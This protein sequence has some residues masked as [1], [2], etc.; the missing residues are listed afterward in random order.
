MTEQILPDAQAIAQDLETVFQTIHRTPELGN[1]EHRTAALIR[2]RLDQLGVEY[3]PVLDTG[4]VAVIRGGR[5]GKTIGFRA[6]IDAL[7]ILEDTG[8]PYAS[9]VPGVMHA[10]GHD[11]H[12]AAL[13]GAAE[14]L[15]ARR[16]ELRGNV[17][18][19]FQPDEEGDGGAARMIAAG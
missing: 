9:Q 6:D 11:F 3:T 8:L 19:F 15:M 5:S 12:T 16:E 7:P 18:L 2:Q 17:K 10:C 13:L 1:R 14:L 4:T